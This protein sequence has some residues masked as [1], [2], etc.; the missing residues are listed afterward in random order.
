M[1]KPQNDHQKNHHIIRPPNGLKAKVGSGHMDESLL[2]K[3]ETVIEGFKDEFVESAKRD[4]AELTLIIE[5]IITT[6]NIQ[7]LEKAFILSHEL[8]GQGGTYGYHLLS[9]IGTLFCRYI[10]KMLQVPQP[11]PAD[12]EVLAAHL[13]SLKGIFHYKIT[14]RGGKIEHEIL[15][16]LQTAINQRVA[17][18]QEQG[19]IFKDAAHNVAFDD[20][21]AFQEE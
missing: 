10:E 21:D 16:G 6:H 3:A 2:K 11:A 12:F 18:W 19:I 8:K 14:G 4:I 5:E 7:H 9:Q 20:D 15:E 1:T 13:D 17:K